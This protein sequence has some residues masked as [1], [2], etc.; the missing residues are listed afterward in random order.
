MNGRI[1]L[2]SRDKIR[3]LNGGNTNEKVKFAREINL[4]V[5]YKT[6]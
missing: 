1:N 3:D 5:F 6:E 2:K 4:Q